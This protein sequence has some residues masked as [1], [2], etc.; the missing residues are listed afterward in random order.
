MGNVG[1]VTG[2]EP[3]GR[4]WET[5]GWALT[6]TNEL[7]FDG[8]GIQACPNSIDGG[9]GIWLQGNSE[10]GYNKD[11]LSVTAAA[12]KVENPIGCRY[13]QE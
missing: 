8:T 7:Q 10:P 6:E 11:C 5:K 12:Y 4:N 3:L 2:A 9:W 13:T 1:Y